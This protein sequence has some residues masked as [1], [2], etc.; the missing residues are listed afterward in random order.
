MT[1]RLLLLIPLAVAAI[2][3]G[4]IFA[5]PAFVASGKHRATIEALASSLTGRQVH[6]N[7]NL[8]LAFIPA[9]EL[10]AGN[11]TIAGPAQEVITARSLTLD[12]AVPALL[13]GRLAARSLTLDAPVIAFPWPLPGGPAAIAP[14]PWLTA[15][16]ARMSGGTISLGQVIFTGVTA[17]IYTGGDGAV[18]ISGTGNCNHMNLQVSVALAAANFSR[19]A[20]L[21]VDVS[22]SAPAPLAAHFSGTLNGN[23]Q[24][25]G[26]L[27][28]SVTPPGMTRIAGTAMLLADAGVFRATDIAATEAAAQ[29]AGS[30]A[31][32]LATPALTLNLTGANFDLGAFAKLRGLAT[33]ALP[34]RLLLAATDSHLG[35][36]AITRLDLDAGSGPDGITLHHLAAVLPGDTRLDLAGQADPQGVLSGKISL[37]TADLNTLLGTTGLPASWGDAK[38]SAAF[39]GSPQRV[40]LSDITGGVGP[41]N[42]SGLLILNRGDHLTAS[43]QLHFDQLD[44]AAAAA[45]LR[46]TA[47]PALSMD[48]EITAD[49]A[50]YAKLQMTHLL[51]DAAW[52]G[53]LLV[54]RVS[55]AIDGGIVDA[56]FRLGA[57]GALTAGR[58]SLSVPSAAPLLALLPAGW[59]PPNALALAPL[60]VAVMAQGPATA[61]ATSAVAT[62]GPITATAAP[63]LNIPAETAAGPLTL[64]H[65]NAIAALAAFGLNAGLA[66]PGAGS[67][68]LRA[69]MSLSPTQMGLPDFVLSLGDLTADGRILVTQDHQITGQIAADTLA[70]PPL[71]ATINIPWGQL[72]TA[73]GTIDLAANR[74]WLAGREILGPSAA[75]VSLGG[76]QIIFTVPRAALAGGTLSGALTASMSANAAPALTATITLA[77]ANAAALSLPVNFPFAVTS[78][79]L[80]AKA[81]LTASGYA[82]ATWAATLAGSASLTGTGGS[83]TGFNLTGLTAALKSPNRFDALRQAALGGT[84]NFT[85]FG[86][87]GTFNHGNFSLTNASLTGGDGSAN[88]TG[89]VDIPDNDLALQIELLPNVNPPLTLNVATIGAWANPKQIPVLRPGLAWTPSP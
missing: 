39:A 78:G 61:L 21:T 5:L 4:I 77:G 45:L 43:G 79:T 80:A 10:I 85:G 89:S 14:P 20:A 13:Q 16:H 17:D 22:G 12:I 75:S 34:V 72:A 47:G 15:L 37:V 40:M 38:F 44:L 58:A 65:P 1:R 8:S 69:D 9:P 33:G 26:T 28:G 88:A 62:L 46:Q 59:Q 86:L 36:V 6:I 66:W 23:S 68:A 57:D 70:L 31:L 32:T 19:R 63:V 87:A 55:A 35:G 50:G 30:A 48:G 74:I 76:D 67:I 42:L 54:R 7:G 51:L 3:A 18:A 2:I 52:S 71:P 24:V 83:L 56:S 60:S 49:R 53:P 82:Q 27:S 73:R 41:D 25:T 84:T 11:V 29:L 64:R 81:S